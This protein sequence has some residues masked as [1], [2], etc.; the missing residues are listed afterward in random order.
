MVQV[1]MK[2]D[3][4]QYRY[5]HKEVKTKVESFTKGISHHK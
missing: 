4:M 2:N 1:A 3:A 5:D